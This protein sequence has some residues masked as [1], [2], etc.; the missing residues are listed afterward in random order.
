MLLSV[1]AAAVDSVRLG[2]GAVVAIVAVAVVVAWLRERVHKPLMQPV[3][4][5]ELVAAV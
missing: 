3:A 2:F 1:A 4:S 5:P